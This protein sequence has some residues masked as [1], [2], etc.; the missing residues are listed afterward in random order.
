MLLKDGINDCFSMDCEMKM[1]CEM[2]AV[3]IL[4]EIDRNNWLIL[5]AGATIQNN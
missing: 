5:L 2:N 3:N 4:R 1:K